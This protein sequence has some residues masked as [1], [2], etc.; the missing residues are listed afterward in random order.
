M[1][2]QTRV[3]SKYFPRLTR[4]FTTYS[5]AFLWFD[6]RDGHIMAVY[7]VD[8]EV[9]SYASLFKRWGGG[10]WSV[11][12]RSKTIRGFLLD[13][14]HLPVPLIAQA[15]N[16]VNRMRLFCFSTNFCSAEQKKPEEFARHGLAAAPFLWCRG[17]SWHGKEWRLRGGERGGGETSGGGGWAHAGK[18]LWCKSRW[19]N[20]MILSFR[21][22]HQLI[23]FTKGAGGFAEHLQQ[24]GRRRRRRPWRERERWGAKK[25]EEE[26][27]WD[28]Q[29]YERQEAEGKT[30][31]V[32]SD[33]KDLWIDLYIHIYTYIHTY[34][35]R[36]KCMCDIVL[37]AF[38]VF[39]MHSTS[40]CMCAT[41]SL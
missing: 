15:F 27:W 17:G 14:E 16:L 19:I 30:L 21:T 40:S 34:I 25:E 20:N 13:V 32:W 12:I 28:R 18:R 35:H 4:G 22:W 24:R 26:D 39:C 29:G 2:A 11:K 41:S 10:K 1:S 23:G 7:G 6:G 33:L 3:N 38:H 8:K 37:Y 5:K 9:S 36:Y 31:V